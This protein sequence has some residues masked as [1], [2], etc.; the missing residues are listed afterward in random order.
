MI[1]AVASDYLDRVTF[2]AIA[3]ECSFED[4]LTAVGDGSGFLRSYSAWRSPWERPWRC[5]P[6][7]SVEYPHTSQ[8]NDTVVAAESDNDSVPEGVVSS[9]PRS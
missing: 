1:D 9:G 2:V 5:C 4:A 3:Q 8:K 7:K 6:W